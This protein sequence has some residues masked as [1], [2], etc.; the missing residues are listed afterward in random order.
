M[1]PFISIF[2]AKNNISF[3]NVMPL[4]SF[5]DLSAITNDGSIFNF[6]QLKNKK[7]LIVNTASNCGYTPQYRQL[8]KTYQLY[9]ERLVVIAFP[10]NNFGGQEPAEDTVIATFCTKNF[11]ISFP[12][13]KKCSVRKNEYQHPVYQ[14]L[15]NKKHNGWNNKAP[16]WNFSKYLI[17]ENGILTHY[18]SPGVSPLGKIMRRAIGA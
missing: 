13:M 17:D 8:Q 12:L 5:Y 7:V 4:V 10:A 18:F 11:G 15:T 16:E 6:E 1:Y 9:K 3:S 14:W 2:S